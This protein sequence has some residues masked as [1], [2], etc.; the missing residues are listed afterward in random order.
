M[1]FRLILA[2]LLNARLAGGII[3]RHFALLRWYCVA[4]VLSY[5][6]GD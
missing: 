2:V 6:Q 5:F 4:D 3:V 1:G